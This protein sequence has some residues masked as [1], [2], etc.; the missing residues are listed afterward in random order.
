[1]SKFNHV[2]SQKFNNLPALLPSM[3]AKQ[4]AID[5]EIVRFFFSRYQLVVAN[6][7]K[8]KD[9]SFKTRHKVYCEEMKFEQ[10]RASSLE[11][12]KYDDRAVNCYIKHLPTGECAGTIRLVLPQHG[13]GALPLEDKFSDAFSCSSLLPSNLVSDGVCEISRLAVPREFRVRQFKTK[14]LPSEKLAKVKQNK[15]LK[16]NIEQLPYLSIAL[17][18][19]ATSVCLHLNMSHAYVLME[20]KLARR[21]K[22]FGIHFNEVGEA[23]S[24]K[25]QRVPYRLSPTT[26]VSELSNTLKRFQQEVHQSIQPSLNKMSVDAFTSTANVP[27]VIKRE[28]RVSVAA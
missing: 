12:D 2:V 8:D 7:E 28:E 26:L 27:F 19:M 3:F 25:G 5:E 11:V 10:T 14:V 24:F 21:M 17:Y 15:N 9:V 22:A 16:F 1:M 18:L 23:I 20:P 4:P 6:D 13:S